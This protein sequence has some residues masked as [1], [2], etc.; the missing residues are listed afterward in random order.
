MIENLKL[1]L[2][3]MGPPGVG[4]GTIA[5]VVA[6]KYNLVHLS[7]GNIFREEIKKQSVL[8]LKVAQIVESGGYVTDDITNEIVKNKLLELQNEDKKVILDGYPRTIAQVNFLDTIE[9]F[10]YE[11]VELYA[12]P[13]LIFERLSGRRQ[14][15][16]CKN[17]FHIKFMP[18]EKGEICDQCSTPLITRKDDQP[19][20]IKKRSQVYLQ[21]TKPLLSHYEKVN[22]LHRF[23]SSS[24]P[25]N[26]ADEIY[27]SLSQL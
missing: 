4:K 25:E 19:E 13:E 15:P 27:K 24:T 22:K 8:G 14:C 20:S 11:V 2:V 26:V 7:T 10:N 3:F 9:G 23:D 17:S 1:N 12:D 21:E 5:A 18:S 6:Q 16:N